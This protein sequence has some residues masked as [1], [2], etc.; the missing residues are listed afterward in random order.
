MSEQIGV[1]HAERIAPAFAALLDKANLSASAIER[2]G[3]TVG[4]GS[5]MGQRVGIAFAKGLVLGTGAQTVAL[6]TLEALAETVGT[7]VTVAIDAR[8]DQVYLQGFDQG[9][10]PTAPMRLVSYAE[11][12]RLFRGAGRLAGSGVS[13]ADP[14][15]NAVG[16]IV[17]SAEALLRLTADRHVS[18]LK[19]LYLRPP[20]AKPPRQAK[21]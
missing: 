4:P 20:D 18:P 6:T 3:V 21:L 12:R 10:A 2:I 9:G 15:I 14:V 11:A 13:A 17:P 8:R 16:G 19:T 1:G 5:F 7:P